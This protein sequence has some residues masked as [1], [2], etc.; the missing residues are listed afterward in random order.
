MN[1]EDEIKAIEYDKD[2]TSSEEEEGEE[3]E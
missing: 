2:P 1:Q 3:R